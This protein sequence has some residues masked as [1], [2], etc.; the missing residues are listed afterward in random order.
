MT[1]YCGGESLAPF[2]TKLTLLALL[3]IVTSNQASWSSLCEFLAFFIRL[4][5][6]TCRHPVIT[7]ITGI[8]SALSVCCPPKMQCL[9]SF[10]LLC[11]RNVWCDCL[12]YVWERGSS[13]WSHGVAVLCNPSRYRGP[14]STRW[15][16]G[17]QNVSATMVCR[18][19]HK[20]TR[21]YTTSHVRKK[22]KKKVS[23]R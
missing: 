7:H 9:F 23:P 2:I 18:H 22:R 16:S 6:H 1:G 21:Q 4:R 3:F 19:A 15:Q 14:T 11:N 13:R 17:L 5:A 12:L 10:A 8:L 20:L